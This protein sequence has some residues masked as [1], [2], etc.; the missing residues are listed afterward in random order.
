MISQ[1]TIKEKVGKQAAE[2]VQNNSIVGIGT[3]STAQYFINALGEKVKDGLN[4]KAVP[5]SERSR[6]QAEHLQIPTIELNDVSFIDLVIDG[7]DE[8]NHD[9]QLIKGGGGA[10][11]RE[12]MVAAAARKYIIIADHTKLVDELG[13][14]PLPVEV[15]SYGWKQVLQHITHNFTIECKLRMKEGKA[16]IT[17]HGHNILDCYFQKI[18]DPVAV[19]RVL[20]NI[21]GIVEDGLF[22]NMAQE[23]LIGMPDGS[24]KKITK[25]KKGSE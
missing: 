4:I 11:L 22:I 15:I 10:L 25:Q 8:I 6:I 17:D 21:P 19:H 9:L 18:H 24:I 1:D 3:G 14:F 16:F 7:A 20:K 12:K 2:L 13:A 23:A 5:T